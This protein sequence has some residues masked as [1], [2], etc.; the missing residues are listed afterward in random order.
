MLFRSP[1]AGRE[2]SRTERLLI[3]F[4]VY[5]T[6]AATAALLNR[7]G[8]KMADVPVAQAS[9]GGT[10]QIDLSL[11]PIAAGEYLIE[12][13]AKGPSGDAKELVPLRI[14]T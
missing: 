4:D 2:F 10:H 5:G 6:A 1:I 3:R 9:A 7:G 11:A 14:G 13:T 12:I 8:T